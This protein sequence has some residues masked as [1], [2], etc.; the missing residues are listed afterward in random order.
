MGSH[1]LPV[2]SDPANPDWRQIEDALDRLAEIA[3]SDRSDNEFYRVLLER[4]VPACGV[5]GGAVWT[6][7]R[8]GEL[9]LEHQLDTDRALRSDLLARRQQLVEDVLNSGEPCTVAANE[10]DSSDGWIALHP[11]R[12]GTQV[13]GAVEF[14]QLRHCSPAQQENLVRLL[15]AMVELTEDFHR[16]RELGKLRQSE[17]VRTQFDRFALG[18]HR[19]L[20]ANETAFAIA[21]DGRRVVG[22][23]RASVLIRRGKQFRA[24]AISGVDVLD[25]APGKSA[26]SND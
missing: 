22:C 14:I 17:Q 21:N 18:I 10:Q 13:L 8:A 24:A 19:S 7:M 15:A 25:R 2:D 1:S 3:K 26:P 16:T 12:C 6:S 9:R 11:F 5:S 23:D 4:I 20:N